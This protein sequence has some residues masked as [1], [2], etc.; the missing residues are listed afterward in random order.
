[1]TEPPSGMLGVGHCL[2]GGGQYVGEVDEPRV[3]GAVRN[4]D[5]GELR[6][7]YPQKFGLSSGHL[8]IELG[9]AE[10]RRPHALVADLG[11]FALGV[12]LLDRTYSN[13]RRRCG[14]G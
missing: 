8:A 3:R 10:E 13:C 4:L 14:T 11:G 1:M 5:M 6:L 12:Q 2:P 9:V 7:G